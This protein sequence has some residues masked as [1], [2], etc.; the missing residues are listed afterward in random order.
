MAVSFRVFL[1]AAWRE[2]VPR[3]SPE[4]FL[5][6]MTAVSTKYA[7]YAKYL[8]DWASEGRGRRARPRAVQHRREAANMMSSESCSEIRLLVWK[9]GSS[10]LP[11]GR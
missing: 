10:R 7:K 4:L 5:W 11:F 6:R 3:V 1:R 8:R 9:G 2:K